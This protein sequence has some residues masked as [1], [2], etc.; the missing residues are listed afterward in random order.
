MVE[1]LYMPLMPRSLHTTPKR[2]EEAA[3]LPQSSALLLRQSRLHLH[4]NL[5]DFHGVSGNHLAE[6]SAYA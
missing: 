2:M 4:T 3:T 6:T 5:G 1:P